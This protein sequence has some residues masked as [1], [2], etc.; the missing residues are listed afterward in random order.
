MYV[1]VKDMLLP[2]KRLNE[3]R[4]SDIKAAKRKSNDVN[5]FMLAQ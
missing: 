5:F 4:W 1:V 3:I 2:E